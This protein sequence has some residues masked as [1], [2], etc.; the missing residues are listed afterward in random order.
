[1]TVYGFDKE[2]F[3][4]VRQA[5]R[6]VEDTPRVGARRRAQTLSASG[7]ESRIA[8][9]V[10]TA[11]F[12][13][14]QSSGNS[15]T[16]TMTVERSTDRTLVGTTISIAAYY[17]MSGASIGVGVRVSAIERDFYTSSASDSQS[18]KQWTVLERICA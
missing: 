12:I 4:R 10:T 8:I 3:D 11:S 1:M 14:G 18:T 13:A 9:G 7:E 5:V 6:R 2:G 15:T 16:L 17:V